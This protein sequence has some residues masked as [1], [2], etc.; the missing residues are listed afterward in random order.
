MARWLRDADDAA[1]RSEAMATPSIGSRPAP[2]GRVPNWPGSAAD[3]EVTVT[4]GRIEVKAP[5]AD[6][7][8]DRG[9]RRADHGTVPQP[10]R[11]EDYLRARAAGRV[12]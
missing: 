7:G 10:S 1:S 5:A 2:P 9:R 3:T 8:A 4:I 6:P 12:G 11:L